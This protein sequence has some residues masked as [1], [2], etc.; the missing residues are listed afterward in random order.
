MLAGP[1]CAC[2]PPCLPLQCTLPVPFLSVPFCQL[3]LLLALTSACS[4]P[5]ATLLPFVSTSKACAAVPPPPLPLPNTA[6]GC[7]RASLHSALLGRSQRA[8]ELAGC[9]AFVCIAYAACE[10]IGP[11]FPTPSE[12]NSFVE[13]PQ[14]QAAALQRMGDSQRVV[15]VDAILSNTVM[16]LNKTKVGYGGG[17][18]AAG[19]FSAPGMSRRG[20]A[21]S[22]AAR[23]GVCRPHKRGTR[24][25]LQAGTARRR[26]GGVGLPPWRVP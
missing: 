20:A 14:E 25:P 18:C 16:P 5:I 24:P 21:G 15:G 22:R 7:I 8:I 23:M 2:L 10:G 4:Y 6:H 13:A 9:G 17:K 3:F 1:T 26:Q 19:P 12:S 11:A